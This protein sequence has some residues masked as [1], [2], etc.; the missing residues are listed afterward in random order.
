MFQ[1]FDKNNNIYFCLFFTKN[2]HYKII[3]IF[4]NYRIYINIK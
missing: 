3:Y 1:L 2:K 4:Y